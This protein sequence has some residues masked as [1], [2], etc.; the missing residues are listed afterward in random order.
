MLIII[1]NGSTSKKYAL[2]GE[3]STDADN[4]DVTDLLSVHYEET[5]TGYVLTEELTAP[6]GKK[7][8]REIPIDKPAF[9]GSFSHFV[10]LL[11]TRNLI[12]SEDDVKSVAFRVV[13]AGTFFQKHRIIDRNFLEKIDEVYEISPLHIKPLKDEIANVADRLPD[14]KMIAV[15]DS[16]FHST[17]T[18]VARTYSIPTKIAEALDIY[19]F[20]YHGISV[21]AAIRQMKKVDPK[22]RKI[23]VCHMGGGTSV[24]AVED[25]KSID[26]SMGYSPLDGVPMAT[27]SGY[28]DPNA[29]LT[30]MDDQD[31]TTS[32]MQNFLYD[33]C[34]MVGISEISSDTRVLLQEAQKGNRQADLALNVYAY[35]INKYIGA[36]VLLMGGV[37]AVVF[38]GTIGERSAEVRRRICE[39]LVKFE[40]LNIKLDNSRN[41]LQV[42]GI[43]KISEDDSGVALHV[44]PTDEDAE[45]ARIVLENKL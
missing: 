26:T 33:R 2:H 37:D 8:S 40:A 4:S 42:K 3:M 35:E 10:D 22:A 13:A 9:L 45:M 23:I 25:G 29:I 12:S 44:V 11:I 41:K 39:R 21:G 30:I 36:F 38:A 20:G 16:A 32:E 1:N 17:M 15:S 7:S 5:P 28:L 31:F 43:G 24:T 27:R 34:G 14:V 18:D 19:R 6:D